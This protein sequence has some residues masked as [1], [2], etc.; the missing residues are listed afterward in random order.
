MSSA[1]GFVEYLVDGEA[2]RWRDAVR[3]AAELAWPSPVHPGLTSSRWPA[4][5]RLGS[6]G[7]REIPLTAAALL[8]YA[9]SAE[10]GTEPR[11]VTLPDLAAWFTDTRQRY[12]ARPDPTIW[13]VFLVTDP[14]ARLDAM[15]RAAG[16]D[17][18]A[19]ADPV[20]QAWALLLDETTPPAADW[21]GSMTYP[22]PNI[23]PGLTTVERVAAAASTR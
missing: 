3:R 11:T 23:G 9:I 17:L 6:D 18:E 15:L 8:V 2:G 10:R 12:P 4:W 20:A 13:D 7:A 16:H 22:G 21:V 1:D 19:G 5:H 14:E